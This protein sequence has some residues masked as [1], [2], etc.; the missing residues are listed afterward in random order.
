M[1][2]DWLFLRT[3][4]DCKS[5]IQNPDDYQLLRATALLRQLLLDAN[6]LLDVVNRDRREKIRFRI[7]DS[8]Q[9]QHTRLVISMN[10]SI[11]TVADGL[12]PGT[13]LP[14]TPVVE[15]SR[16]QFLKHPVAYASGR[17]YTVGEI[18]QHCANILGGVHF[19]A[20]QS[21][22]EGMLSA[23]QRNCSAV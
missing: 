3:L 10:P 5:A 9:T 13:S 12:Y 23:L 1:D 7:A 6:R 21:E 8:W 4:N 14:N 18:V 22:S 15:L 2:P 17:Y 16:D 11:Y 19:G 20:P